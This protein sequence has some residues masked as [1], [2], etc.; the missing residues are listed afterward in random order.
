MV[1]VFAAC[2]KPL[3]NGCSFVL[4]RRKAAAEEDYM[5]AA[6]LQAQL[7]DLREQ[8]LRHDQ[9]DPEVARL[10]QRIEDAVSQSFFHKNAWILAGCAQS[11]LY[12]SSEVPRACRS[13]AS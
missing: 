7:S 1:S 2:C 3:A 6:R 11:Q 4:L 13:S 10:E 8:L 5:E 9:K 12:F